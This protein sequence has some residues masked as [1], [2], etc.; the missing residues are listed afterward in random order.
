MDER[1]KYSGAK[2]E[3]VKYVLTKDGLLANKFWI[4]DVLHQKNY[5]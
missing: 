5:V 3:K 4:K 1:K 2:K